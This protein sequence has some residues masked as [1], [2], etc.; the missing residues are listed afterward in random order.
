MTTL[1]F[2]GKSGKSIKRNSKICDAFIEIL[3]SMAN[4]SNGLKKQNSA[5]VRKSRSYTLTLKTK[6]R[7]FPQVGI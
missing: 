2:F 4:L 3:Q 7:H 5:R 1:Y 6:Y